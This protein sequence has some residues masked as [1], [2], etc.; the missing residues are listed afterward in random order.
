MNSGRY[1]TVSLVG[2]S[3]SLCHAIVENM[4]NGFELVTQKKAPA[5]N[6]V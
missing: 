2:A 3:S 6:G 1:S 5:E 4:F